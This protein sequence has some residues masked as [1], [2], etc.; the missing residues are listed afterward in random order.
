M[1]DSFTVAKLLA[2]L[3][4]SGE[5]GTTPTTKPKEDPEPT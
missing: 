5:I 2:L 3:V 1:A 4:A